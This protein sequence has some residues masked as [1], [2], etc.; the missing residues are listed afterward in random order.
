M[1]PHLRLLP[2]EVGDL[3][4]EHALCAPADWRVKTLWFG[5]EYLARAVEFESDQR[6]LVARQQGRTGA[7][8]LR[9]NTS[10]LS[11]RLLEN[12]ELILNDIRQNQFERRLAFD[13]NG[14]LVEAIEQ[15]Q[16]LLH[17][18]WRGQTYWVN[19]SEERFRFVWRGF[20]RKHC[21]DEKW[22]AGATDARIESDIATMLADKKSDCA[23]AWNWLDLS[24]RERE[25][26]LYTVGRGSLAEVE[27]LLRAVCMGEASELEG[28]NW[29]LM[30][31][32]AVG[33]G[34][35]YYA[36]GAS[37]ILLRSYLR[38][39]EDTAQLSRGQIRMAVLIL[40]HFELWRNWDAQTYTL[41][42]ERWESGG[43]GHFWQIPFSAPSMHDLLEA[44]LLLRDFLRDQVSPDEISEL[45]GQ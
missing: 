35:E 20:D 34:T 17:L 33:A 16:A 27:A 28:A 11:T 32:V 10:H 13:Q 29:R 37:E 21:F 4:P 44:R 12:D 26:S 31:N 42:Q 45:I 30:L 41:V 22:R 38:N 15:T 9:L 39:D 43:G 14:R 1:L 3:K 5:G 19:G 8:L 40:Q 25:L 36:S 18:D 24:A 23:F 7:P 2:H 6:T